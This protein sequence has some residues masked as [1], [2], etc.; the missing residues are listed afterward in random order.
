METGATVSVAVSTTAT[1]GAVT[2]P[3]ATTWSCDLSGLVE[4]SNDITAT[5]TDAAGNNAT[6]TASILYDITPPA[7]NVNAVTT[8][9]NV[10]SQTIT[11][12]MEANA[13]V[14]V[15]VSTSATVGAVTY[16]TATT[17]S[18][19][20]SG[21]VEG[22]NEIT[23]TATDAAGN[24]AT[25]VTSI[26]YDITPPAVGV[27]A[28][29]TPTNI[30]TQTITGTMEDGATVS[31]TVNTSATVGAVTYPTA[32]SWSCTLS[33][34]AEES[35]TITVTAADQAGNVTS[36]SSTIL[37]DSI[38][39]A[40]S[41]SSPPAGYIKIANPQLQYSINE[42]NTVSAEIVKLNGSGVSVA[43]GDS[44]SLGDGAHTVRVE[45]TDE[46]GN[47]GSAEVIFTVDT[48]PPAVSIDYVKSPI[49][50]AIRTFTGTMEQDAS[51]TVSVNTSA[52][53]GPVVYNSDKTAWSCEIS[54]LVRG[55]HAITTT[56]HDAAGNNASAQLSITS[57]AK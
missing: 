30:N 12:T 36:A 20:L 6:A 23:A 57:K 33:N 38:A 41:I 16:P 35:N 4:G 2:Y 37:F 54:G 14:S 40:V 31:I 42:A 39:P 10:N 48:I 32:T 19:D 18:C 34:L 8:P 13:N 50:E 1:V 24:S 22:A 47:I 43:N 15:A 17:W 46:A 9:T 45:V 52:T 53:V 26:L 49:K 44:F 7:V 28:V 11:G 25:A 27:N 21:L 29:V 3:T 55:D 56:A 51:V 5:A